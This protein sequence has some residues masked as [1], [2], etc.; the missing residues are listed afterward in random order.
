[1]PPSAKSAVTTASATA[2]HAIARRRS[3]SAPQQRQRDDAEGPRH[4]GDGA[5]SQRIS[6]GEDGDPGTWSAN[7]PAPAPRQ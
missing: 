1:M 7:S 4:A 3:A 6:A 2:H 5:E